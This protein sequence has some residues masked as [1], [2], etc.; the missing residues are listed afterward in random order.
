[1]LHPVRVLARKF[2]TVPLR[3]PNTNRSITRF[4]THHPLHEPYLAFTRRPAFRKLSPR[5]YTRRIGS[6]EYY[7]NNATL[8]SYIDRRCRFRGHSYDQCLRIAHDKLR[9]FCVRWRRGIWQF[10]DATR[11]IC[12]RHPGNDQ[13]FK[14]TCVDRCGYLDEWVWESR[15]FTAFLWSRFDSE[16]ERR[17]NGEGN[18]TFLD[19]LLDDCRYDVV[20]SIRLILETST[21][22]IDFTYST[23]DGSAQTRYPGQRVE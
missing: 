9:E 12:G 17:F 5:S 21:S 10:G 16:K 13:F 2:N 6:N 3:D 23:P 8:C 19:S 7:P 11:R 15:Q 20:D 14:R 18:Y 22:L 1:N 4:L